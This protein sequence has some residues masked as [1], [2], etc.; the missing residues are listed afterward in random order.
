L[1]AAEVTKTAP[2]ED[3]MLQVRD[4]ADEMLGV[5][6]DRYHTPLYNFYSKLTG[7]RTLSED[8][9]QEVFLRILKYKRSYTPG[10]NFRG[11][12]YQIARNTRVDHLR[13]QKPETPWTPEIEPS[14][15]PQDTAQQQQ[16]VS[17]LHRALMQ[18]SEEKRELLILSRLQ[19]LKYDEIAKVLGCNVVTVRVRVHRALEELRLIYHLMQAGPA[20]KK[21]QATGAPAS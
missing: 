5:L 18:M 9:V 7:D 19:E 2:D 8:L 10:S 11:W 6:F 15:K 3:V 13:K 21:A 12:I 14:A 16:E 1:L 4:G 17:M 20:T